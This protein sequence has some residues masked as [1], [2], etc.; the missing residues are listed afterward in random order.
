MASN[1]LGAPLPLPW[2]AGSHIERLSDPGRIL[3]ILQDLARVRTRLHLQ[4]VQEWRVASCFLS[5]DPS[6]GTCVL[7][8]CRNGLELE[9]ILNASE[10]AASASLGDITFHFRF[11][12]PAV[13]RFDG[14]PAFLA[15]LPAGIYMVP[16]RRHFRV[17]LP[18]DRDFRCQI[19]LS[20]GQ[21]VEMEVADLSVSGVGLRSMRI[22]PGQLPVGT[23]IAQC[24]LD[25]GDLGAMKLALQVVRH[26]KAWHGNEAYNH[27]GCRFGQ[28]D[29]QSGKWLQRMV[30]ALE[31]AGRP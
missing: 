21:L 14:G 5:V 15:S 8:W 12:T 27:F 31:L 20:D 2:A 4:P 22:G 1:A 25:L 23:S 7:A 24:C 18:Q 30:F 19:L 13:T 6:R 29:A 3:Q 28:M 16:R 11:A 17:R 9:A 26:R 10:L